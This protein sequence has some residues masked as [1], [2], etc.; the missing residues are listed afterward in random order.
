MSTTNLQIDFGTL[1]YRFVAR[2]SWGDQVLSCLRRGFGDSLHEGSFERTVH[3]FRYVPR[4]E[5]Y[6][7]INSGVLPDPLCVNAESDLPD[8][9]WQFYEDK[10]GYITAY[11]AESTAAFLTSTG[12]PAMYNPGIWLPWR[13][14]IEDIIKRGG[15]L[16]HGGLAQTGSRGWIFSAPPGGGKTTSMSRFPP[17]WKV[18]SDDAALVWPEEA[19][20]FKASPLPGWGDILESKADL[21]D[22]PIC[23]NGRSV[24]LHGVFFIAKAQRHAVCRMRSIEAAGPLYRALSEHPAVL[25]ARQSKKKKIFQAAC[26]LART[27]P[28]WKLAL[29]REGDFS[30]LL[31]DATEDQP[32]NR[33]RC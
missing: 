31:E 17:S 19:G 8:R 11:N 12:L 10:C 7:K 29:A 5:D 24:A 27:V 1:H 14:L 13:L 20:G 16:I 25:E 23:E 26:C 18:L 21:I 33:R 22:R 4:P 9:G 6:V 3:L 2:D 15:G 32:R 28:S 30:A